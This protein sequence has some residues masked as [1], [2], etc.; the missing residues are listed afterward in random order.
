MSVT[1]LYIPCLLTFVVKFA[2][3]QGNMIG[4]QEV[5]PI[6]PE[7]IRNSMVRINMSRVI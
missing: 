2:V 5:L 3:G 6:K 4:T 1:E 7:W